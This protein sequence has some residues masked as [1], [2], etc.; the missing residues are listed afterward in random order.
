MRSRKFSQTLMKKNSRNPRSLRNKNSRN[1]RSLR[2]K[3][4]IKKLRKYNK[5]KLNGGNIKLDG[6]IS[7]G[8]ITNAPH[9]RKINKY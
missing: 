9:K 8:W 1:S 7:Q 5:T 3:S 6:D 2:N 4:S